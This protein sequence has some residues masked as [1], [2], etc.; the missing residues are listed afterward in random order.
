MGN[1]AREAARFDRRARRYDR[2]WMQPVL[3]RPVHRVVLRALSLS[4][5]E[6]FLEVGCGTGNLALAAVRRCGRAVGVDP[7]TAMIDLARDKAAVLHP[8]MR[9][10]F[11]VGAAEALPFPDASFDAAAT[12]VSMHHWADLRAGVAELRR[13]LV[14]GGR[15]VVADLRGPGLAKRGSGRRL[16]QVMG[17]RPRELARAL[18][19][20]GFVRVRVRRKGALSRLI[21][22][23]AAEA[24]E[25]R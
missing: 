23:L 4:R 11:V 20:A 22:F 8:T 7:S 19:G 2:S 10:R 24:P 1:V 16:R 15:L 12:S 17:W 21:V 14:P 13:V 6:R 3:F 5:G 9:A 18:Q 25:T